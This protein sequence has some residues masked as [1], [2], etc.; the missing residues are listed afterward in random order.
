MKD[1]KPNDKVVLDG[2]Q[3]V[4]NGMKVMAKEVEIYF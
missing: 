4:R 1:L 3:K 2:I